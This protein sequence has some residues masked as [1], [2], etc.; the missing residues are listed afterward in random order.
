M[1]IQ[2]V[3][4]GVQIFT[5]KGSSHLDNLHIDKCVSGVTVS[6]SKKNSMKNCEISNTK[7]AVGVT[8]SSKLF[9]SF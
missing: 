3:E 5:S 6:Q 1:T 7:V 8:E 9:T 4:Y 2:D